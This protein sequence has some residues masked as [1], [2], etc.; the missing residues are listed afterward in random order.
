MCQALRAKTSL[1]AL[2]SALGDIIAPRQ[3]FDRRGALPSS[4]SAACGTAPADDLVNA[5]KGE[6]GQPA[7]FEETLKSAR[8]PEKALA[9]KCELRFLPP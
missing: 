8:F 7:Q 9:D 6:M 5:F 1:L 3:S 4:L 2:R